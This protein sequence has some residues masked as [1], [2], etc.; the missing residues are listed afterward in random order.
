MNSGDCS[1]SSHLILS[2]SAGSTMSSTHF[3]DKSL[4]VTDARTD[5]DNRIIGLESDSND[6]ATC[7]GIVKNNYLPTNVVAFTPC[8][9]FVKRPNRLFLQIHTNVPSPQRFLMIAS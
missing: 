7:L 1:N 5:L 2:G 4:K 9:C 3:V 6:E 8:S